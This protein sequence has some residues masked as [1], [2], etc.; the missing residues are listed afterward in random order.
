[1][2]DHMPDMTRRKL[3]VATAAAG[4]GAVALAETNFAEA[5]GGGS[6]IRPF[7]IQFSDAD[8]GDLRRRVNATKFPER[9][10]VPEVRNRA[11]DGQIFTQ[12]VPLATVQKLARYW[13]TEYDWR[14]C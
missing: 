4:V 2:T 8:V 7:R 12:G 3:L 5:T 11:Y 1:M 6:S 10:T 14:K 13:G 9:E